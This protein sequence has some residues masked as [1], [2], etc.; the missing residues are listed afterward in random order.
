MLKGELRDLVAGTKSS[1][2]WGVEIAIAEV[3]SI[4]FSH[5]LSVAILR[6][7]E[8]TLQAKATV[9][10]AEAQRKKLELEGR[11]E[12]AKERETLKGRTTGLKKMMAQ[13]NLEG[14]AVLGAETARAVTQ[15][16]GQKTVVIGTDG[17]KE[18]IGIAKA[19]GS[20]LKDTEEKGGVS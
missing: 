10:E 1:R 18:L 12:G 3:K 19:A 14:P 13:L 2:P 9:I 8:A 16:P 6:V 5:E 17:F 20:V 11:G 15:N 7:P 4:I